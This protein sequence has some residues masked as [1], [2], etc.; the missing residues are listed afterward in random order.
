MKILKFKTNIIAISF[1]KRTNQINTKKVI[2]IVVE[3]AALDC[4][5]FF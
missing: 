5:H 2:P 1:Q 3:D 4:E